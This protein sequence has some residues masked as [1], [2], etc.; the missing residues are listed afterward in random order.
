MLSMLVLAMTAEAKKP[1]VP[2]PPPVGWAREAN[3]KGDCYFPPDFGKMLEADRKMARAS[4]LD[5]MKAQWLGQREDGVS[6]DPNVVDS[7]ETTLLGRPTNIE[8]VAAKNLEYCKA[9]MLGGGTDSWASWLGGL[10]SKLT[11][12]ECLR[13]LTYTLFD[14]LEIGSGWQRPITLCQGNKAHISAT[15]KDRY[16]VRDDGPWINAEGDSTRPTVNSNSLPC[17]IE[18]CFE[19]TLTGRFVT[20]AGVETIFVIGTDAVYV[21]PENGTLYYGIND[22]TWYDNK[23]FKSATIEDRTAITVEPAE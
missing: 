21:A 11:A 15:T 2:P 16:R 20:D 17:N 4:T 14:Y 7:V 3:W 22:D 5:Q 1:K 10:T 13:P 9:V 19:G 23:Y 12:G 18:N 8:D 6:F